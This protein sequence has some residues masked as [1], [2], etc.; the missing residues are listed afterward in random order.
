MVVTAEHTLEMEPD[1]GRASSRREAHMLARHV[2]GQQT[3]STLRAVK[4]LAERQQSLVWMGDS[5]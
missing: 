1:L 3:R 2:L 5:A 4:E